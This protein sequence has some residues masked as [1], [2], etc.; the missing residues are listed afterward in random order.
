M[1]HRPLAFVPLPFVLAA[2]LVFAAGSPIGLAQRATPPAGPAATLVASTAA[3]PE[4]DLA[5]VAPLP[6]TEA[7]R[8]EFEAYVAELQNLLGV[9][10]ASV[11]VV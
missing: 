10:G 5:G 4:A 6:M 7:R 3:T 9:P 8:T 11:A 2:L 1:R